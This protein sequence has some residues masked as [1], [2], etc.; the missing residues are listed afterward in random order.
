M[1]ERAQFNYAQRWRIEQSGNKRLTQKRK[2]SIFAFTLI[3]FLVVALLASP[4]VWQFIL[5]YQLDK[6]EQSI[7]AYHDVAVTMEDVDR[8]KGEIARMN[9]FLAISQGKSK[10]PREVLTQI[11]K[12]LPTGTTVTSFS[13]QADNSVQINVDVPGPVDL[14]KFWMNFRDSGLFT[15]FDMKTVSLTDEVQHLSLTLKLK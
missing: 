4:W 8:L 1:K 13:L 5:N 14:A 2:K 9:S 11:N 12:L 7:T 6:I 15:D 10:K 3:S